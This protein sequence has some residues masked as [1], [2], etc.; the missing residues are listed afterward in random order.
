MLEVIA[1]GPLALFQDRGRAGFAG[2]GVSPSGSFDRLSAARANH[3]V[4]NAAEA[5]VIEI[6]IGGFQAKVLADTTAIITGTASTVTITGAR[7]RESYT[8][9]LLDLQ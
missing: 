2:T 8:N 6:L 7:T 1:T 9:T 4:G 3:A 5:P